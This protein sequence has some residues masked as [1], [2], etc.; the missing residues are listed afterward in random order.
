MKPDL[1]KGVR[2]WA[3]AGGK[4]ETPVLFPTRES[5]R[6]CRLKT[7]GEYVVPVIVKLAPRKK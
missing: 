4:L 5:A 3:L 2:A 6:R 1:K 7:A